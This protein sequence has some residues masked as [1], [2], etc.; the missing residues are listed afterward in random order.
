MPPTSSRASLVLLHQTH[1]HD[2][3]LKDMSIPHRRKGNNIFAE[4]FMPYQGGDY[5]GIFRQKIQEKV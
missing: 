3:I 1:F 4:L 2:S 5:D